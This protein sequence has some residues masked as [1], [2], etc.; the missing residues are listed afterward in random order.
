MGEVVYQSGELAY[1][2]DNGDEDYNLAG[3]SSAI[4]HHIS[5]NSAVTAGELQVWGKPL[6]ASYFKRLVDNLDLSDETLQQAVFRGL[7]TVIRVTPDGTT[8]P[9][10]DTDYTITIAGY[11]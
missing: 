10:A 8:P 1:N 9:A 4:E 11:G 2:S 5:I 7:Y 6:G 3:K